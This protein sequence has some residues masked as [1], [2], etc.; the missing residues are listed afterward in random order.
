MK[1]FNR[2]NILKGIILGVM[3]FSPLSM[4]GC[5]KT[6][7]NKTVSDGI[8][9]V[10]GEDLTKTEYQFFYNNFLNTFK[11]YYNGS[12]GEIDFSKSL[13]GQKMAD[14]TSV[15]DFIKKSTDR[16]IAETVAL[17]KR[18]E[19]EKLDINKEELYKNYIKDVKEKA[20]SEAATVNALLAARYGEDATEENLKNITLKLLTASKA[21]EMIVNKYTPSEKEIEQ[22][23]QE[24]KNNIDRYTFR[25]VEFYYNEDLDLEGGKKNIYDFT[26]E[27][28]A[29]A[30]ERAHKRAEEFFK[31]AKTEEDFKKKGFETAGFTEGEPN[32]VDTSLFDQVSTY[33]IFSEQVPW[34]T[35]E[36]RKTGDT[37]IIDCDNMQ[38]Y[39]VLYFINRE[40]PMEDTLDIKQ[41][42][43]NTGE[44]AERPKNEKETD[45]EYEEYNKKLKE[46]KVSVK[47][48]TKDFI[49]EWYQCSKTEED[50]DKLYE[51]YATFKNNSKGL[52]ANQPSKN[53]V[54]TVRKWVFDKE[55]EEGDLKV[56]EG[57][58]YSSII[59]IKSKN[60]P[61]W[62]GI[63]LQLMRN[64]YNTHFLDEEV[65]ELL[66]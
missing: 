30:K 44:Y 23:Y 43:I 35:D 42:V 49:K 29:E 36:S 40:K 19:K 27:E 51:K 1:I 3:V 59:Y 20:D 50:F 5:N 48:K 61:E 60:G 21:R 31:V 63:V 54:P 12:K 47:E 52:I 13:D 8:V 65:E 11:M 58:D 6:E 39:V 33:E 15:N 7:N 66:K 38:S 14:G 10:A 28:R 32:A 17:N 56:F 16:M 4:I 2:K 34:V 9:R 46:A 57:T 62:K 53:F 24:H 45:K 41:F 55:R 22:Y 26:E 37:A 64:D 18:A 25:L